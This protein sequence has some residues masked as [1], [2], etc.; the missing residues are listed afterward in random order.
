MLLLGLCRPFIAGLMP[1]HGLNNPMTNLT[2]PIV[3]K[4]ILPSLTQEQVLMLVEKADC[5]RDKAIIALFAESGS[6]S[7]ELTNIKQKDI[8]W[9]KPDNKNL[10]QRQKG[11]LCSFWRAIRKI[12]QR[13]ACSISA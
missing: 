8:H 10:R 12:P 4:P 2:A 3:G 1:E 9:D 7:S 11:G 13:M 6:R 5:V